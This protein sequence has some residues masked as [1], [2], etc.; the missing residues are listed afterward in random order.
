[1]AK[2][3]REDGWKAE[4]G[5]RNEPAARVLLYHFI[6]HKSSHHDEKRATGAGV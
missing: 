5:E 1:M 4:R 3:K 6:D 2:D